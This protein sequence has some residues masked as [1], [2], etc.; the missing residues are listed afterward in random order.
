MFLQVSNTADRPK[1]HPIRRLL[2]LTVILIAGLWCFRLFSFTEPLLNYLFAG[3]VFSIPF[4]AIRPLLQLPRIPKVIGCIALSPI[5]MIDLLI[6]LLFVSCGS[7]EMHHYR[8]DS[9][10]QELGKVEQG[11]YSVHLLRDCGGGPTVA[12]TVW[13][14]QRLPLV[15]GLYL[16]RKVD[17]FYGA[18]EGELTFVGMN[19]VRLEIPRGVESNWNQAIVRTYSLKPHVYF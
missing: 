13:I 7:P 10:I 17:S 9:C 16:F 12:F 15:P 1:P 4:F 6:T 3:A 2:L 11:G 5:L 14:E 18:Y 8:K 19:E